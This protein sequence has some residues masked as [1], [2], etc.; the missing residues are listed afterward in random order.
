[1]MV[2]SEIRK[3]ELS[4]KSVMMGLDGKIGTMPEFSV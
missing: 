1:M 2:A 3:I 4:S